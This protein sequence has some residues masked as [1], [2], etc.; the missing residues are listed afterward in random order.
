M[1]R[2]SSNL[3]VCHCIVLQG[4][5]AIRKHK[6][7]IVLLGSF[8]SPWWVNYQHIELSNLF[9]EKIPIK[10]SNIT[11]DKSVIGRL[12][13]IF[14]NFVNDCHGLE[15]LLR[16]FHEIAIHKWKFES[17]FLIRVLKL[18]IT[19]FLSLLLYLFSEFLYF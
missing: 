15:I 9:D 12:L 3:T 6:L 8:D 13:K 2:D 18:I 1:E 17:L 16:I 5:F 19:K 11:V 4:K 14:T 7:G 10:V